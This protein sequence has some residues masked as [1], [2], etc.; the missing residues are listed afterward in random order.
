MG[1]IPARTLAGPSTLIS[2]LNS[3]YEEIELVSHLDSP[4]TKQ[5]LESKWL[6]IVKG[7]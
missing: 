6:N 1:L 4:E 3:L 2:R 7:H 5:I